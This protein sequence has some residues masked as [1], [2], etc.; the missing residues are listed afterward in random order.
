M[1]H[2]HRIAGDCGER[3]VMP[4]IWN[5]MRDDSEFAIIKSRLA[6]SFLRGTYAATDIN[7]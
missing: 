3:P 4:D 5:P 1:N 2:N 7:R 6:A